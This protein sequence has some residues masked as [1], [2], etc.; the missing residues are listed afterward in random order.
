[1]EEKTAKIKIINVDYM[2]TQITFQFKIDKLSTDIL[3]LN[4][5]IH[6]V[7]GDFSSIPIKIS[8]EGDKTKLLGN[9]RLALKTYHTISEDVCF[10]IDID[11][12]GGVNC[13]F[14]LFEESGKV[15][16]SGRSLIEFSY[17]I[18]G[19][20]DKID[21]PYE[22]FPT[23]LET[24]IKIVEDKNIQEEKKEGQK[25]DEIKKETKDSLESNPFIERYSCLCGHLQGREH[26]NL[27]N[28]VKCSICGGI[29][30][31]RD[32]QKEEKKEKQ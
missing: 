9:L 14:M 21:I 15:D 10:R 31:Y 19:N 2:H 11:S 25:S 4:Y 13:D 17:I 30:E 26:Y 12:F 24:F 20:M 7:N 3:E 23:F 16:E 29:V 27:D 28:P 18:E 22:I 32:I 5:N 6:A 1:M 8:L